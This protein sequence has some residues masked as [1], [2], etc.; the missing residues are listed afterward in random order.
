MVCSMRKVDVGSSAEHG[1]SMR[2]TRGLTANERAMHRRCC[3]PPDSA[4]P[5]SPN[6]SLTSFQRPPLVRDSSM[7]SSLSAGLTR[8]NFSPASTF[9]AMVMAGNGL[10]FWNTMPMWRR[11]SMAR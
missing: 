11:V 7:R 3:C 9:S 10:G 6:R 1:S 2:R 4:P 8:E 5:S